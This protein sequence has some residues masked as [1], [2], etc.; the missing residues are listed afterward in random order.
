MRACGVMHLIKQRLCS[1]ISD[2]HVLQEGNAVQV[3]Q[4]RASAVVAAG[5]VVA[6]PETGFILNRKA[7]KMRGVGGVGTIPT[8]TR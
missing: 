2:V 6:V 1:Q 5:G 8:M 7:V 3:A 4:T